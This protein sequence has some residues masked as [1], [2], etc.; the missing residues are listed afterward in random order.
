MKNPI[1]GDGSY[2]KILQ[3]LLESDSSVSGEKI[4]SILGF[5]RTTIH[6]KINNMILEGFS[7]SAASKRGYYLEKVPNEITPTQLYLYSNIYNNKIP[8]YFYDCVD[9]TNIESDRLL[10]DG[11]SPPFCV[12][13]LKQTAGKGRLGRKWESHSKNNLYLSTVFAPNTSPQNLQCFTLGVAIE[14]CEVIKDI[15]PRLPVKIKWPNDLYINNKKIAGMLTEAKIDNDRIQSLV[16]GF[17]LNINSQLIAVPESVKKNATSLKIQTSKEF[18]M[19]SIA[20]KMLNA[21]VCAYIKSQRKNKS[22]NLLKSWSKFDYL[23]GKNLTL[24]QNGRT[25]RG[26][27][28][29]VNSN[30][31]L[32]IKTLDGYIESIYSGDI[33][34]NS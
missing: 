4:A 20:I 7:I 26:I 33:N 34:L 21:S 2:A 31:A 22:N 19:N 16:F 5:S 10:R 30:G 24:K 15:I 25:I 11:V 13:A 6:K 3:I 28:C 23:K 32:Q 29:G 1:Q 27:A 18:N 9:S 14:I 8:I 17:G 12:I